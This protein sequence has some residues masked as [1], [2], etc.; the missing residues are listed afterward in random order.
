M[1]QSIGKSPEAE[2]KIVPSP[3]RRLS[4]WET[5]KPVKYRS[6]PSYGFADAVKQ[7]LPILRNSCPGVAVCKIPTRQTT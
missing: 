5:G 7:L 3:G 1:E 6:H 2:A 4:A